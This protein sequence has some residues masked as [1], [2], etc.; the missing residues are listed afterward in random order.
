VEDAIAALRPDHAVFRTGFFVFPELLFA[1]AVAAAFPAV[2]RARVAVLDLFSA[3]TIAAC[4]LPAIFGADGAVLVVLTLAVGAVGARAAVLGAGLA[5]LPLFTLGVGAVGARAAVLG[6]G[7]AVLVSLA[8]PVRTNGL[9]LALLAAP[10]VGDVVP[11]VALLSSFF[12]DN[13]VAALGRGLAVGRTGGAV[14]LVVGL[15]LPV[16][17]ARLAINRAGEARLISFAHLV[18][19]FG[20]AFL[21]VG[22]TGLAVFLVRIADSVPAGGNEVDSQIGNC[23]VVGLHLF[24]NLFRYRIKG[25]GRSAGR[26]THG[27]QSQ[28]SSY[29]PS[30]HYQDL[31]PGITHYSADRMP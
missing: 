22:R 6:A 24:G 14:L 27:E 4:A 23:A 8:F 7:L 12:L 16:A 21:A 19:A 15:A 20:T 10:V 31:P 11:V 29:Q 5:V 9:P 2:V 18:A 28:N 3:R 13:P 30:F 17:A 1:N 26:T 25:C